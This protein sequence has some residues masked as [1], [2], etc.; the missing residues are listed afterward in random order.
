MDDLISKLKAMR[1]LCQSEQDNEGV[2]FSWPAEAPG[3]W[4][5]GEDIEASIDDM[6]DNLR[7]CVQ[8]AAENHLHPEPAALYAKV[9]VSTDE[10]LR[11]CLAGEIC[12]VS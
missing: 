7:E 9:L 12:A 4:G 1:I 10:E 8:I 6:I 11:E 5:K 3:L 2:W